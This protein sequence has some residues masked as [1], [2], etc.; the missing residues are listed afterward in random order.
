MRLREKCNFIYVL[1]TQADTNILE[2]ITIA[3]LKRYKC[4]LSGKVIIAR[5]RDFPIYHTEYT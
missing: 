5:E 2:V 4:H 3:S 1:V